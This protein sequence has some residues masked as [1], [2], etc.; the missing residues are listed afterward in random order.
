MVAVQLP[1]CASQPQPEYTSLGRAAPDA[2]ACRIALSFKT[3][4]EQTITAS[5]PAA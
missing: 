2:T 5:Q 4:Q 1:H 3:L